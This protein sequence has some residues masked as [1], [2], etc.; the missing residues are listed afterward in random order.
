MEKY[1]W[2]LKGGKFTDDYISEHQVWNLFNNFFSS[3]SAKNTAY[4]FIFMKS[5]V[6]GETSIWDLIL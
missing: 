5:L 2:R 6:A 4:K 1:S 3:K